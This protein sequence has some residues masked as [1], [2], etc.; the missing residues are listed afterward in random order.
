M[1]VRAVL[2]DLYDTLVWTD[3]ARV[4]KALAGRLGLDGEL[5]ARAFTETR[6][7]R[8]VGAYGDAAGDWDAVLA[9]AGVESPPEVAIDAASLEHELLRGAV[10]LFP[11]S[12]QVVTDLRAR[13]LKTALISNCSHATRPVVDRLGLP[14]A[15]DAVMLSFELGVRKPDPEIYR[16]TLVALG[17]VD[18][19]DAVFVDDQ[20]GYCDGAR[21]LGI[22]A[23]LMSRGDEPEE[24]PGG[25]HPRL[26]DL[27][28][29]LQ[30]L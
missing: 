24:E 25:D 1:P 5:I 20:P 17:G 2:L 4:R 21:A 22:G 30:H 29:L 13:G 8:N 12:M 14:E 9:W 15:F 16:R 23:F 18:A 11:E 7:A 10:H 28:Q 19:E 6:A 27:R 3:W 26:A